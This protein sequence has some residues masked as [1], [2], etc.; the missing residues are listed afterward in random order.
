[1]TVAGLTPCTRKVA[2]LASLCVRDISVLGV[3]GFSEGH[4]NMYW[5]FG[6]AL[7][8]VSIVLPFVTIV[9]PPVIKRLSLYLFEVLR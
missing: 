7:P 1:M 5:V 9:M 4:R 6:S 8:L 3:G 2:P